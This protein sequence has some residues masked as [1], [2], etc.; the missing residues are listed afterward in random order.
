MEI[1]NYGDGG[2]GIRYNDCLDIKK[3]CLLAACY[4]LHF[5]I[6]RD[7]KEKF[8]RKILMVKIKFFTECRPVSTAN[9]IRN[10]RGPKK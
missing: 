7:L 1:L 8:L 6:H 10:P 5:E 9:L 3:L 4:N 2:G